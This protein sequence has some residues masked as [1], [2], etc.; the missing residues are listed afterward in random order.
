M[1]QCWTYN[2]ITRIFSFSA[3]QVSFMYVVCI[4]LKWNRT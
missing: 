1:K 3:L 4:Y 2:I